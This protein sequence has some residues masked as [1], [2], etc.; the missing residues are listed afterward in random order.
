[1]KTS[2]VIRPA[3][4]ALALVAWLLLPQTVHS[5]YNPSTGRWLSRD[6]IAEPGFELMANRSQNRTKPQ[7]QV[8]FQKGLA[9]LLT[10]RPALALRIQDRIRKLD[11]S[12]NTEPFSIAGNLYIVV[13]NDPVSQI[14]VLGLD[15]WY[16]YCWISCPCRVQVA[17]VSAWT[18]WS[19]PDAVAQR[20]CGATA[21]FFC[22]AIA[23]P[24][25]INWLAQLEAAEV[26][27]QT[28]MIFARP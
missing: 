8:H 14:D 6:P 26:Y 18:L 28:C 27:F 19:V 9:E 25:T 5:F 12:S 24:G 22:S 7:E 15:I 23:M 4:L 13:Q 2:N 1:M 3:T 17:L 20:C 11:A 10:A 21:R 16:W